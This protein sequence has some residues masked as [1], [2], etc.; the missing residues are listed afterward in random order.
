M[1]KPCPTAGPSA[2]LRSGGTVQADVSS[3]TGQPP[4]PLAEYLR[5][6]VGPC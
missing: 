2:S 1:D 6:L 5:A 4:R 3:L